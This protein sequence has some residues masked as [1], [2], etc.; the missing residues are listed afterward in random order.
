MIETGRR[1]DGSGFSFKGTAVGIVEETKDRE[2]F[3]KR[4]V[5]I[6]LERARGLP[7]TKSSY[8]IEESR[9]GFK[10]FQGVTLYARKHCIDSG[11]GHPFPAFSFGWGNGIHLRSRQG[12]TGRCPTGRDGQGVG[13]DAA[14]R[15]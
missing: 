2:A 4:S 7:E 10:N 14:R 13:R 5:L 8:P 9:Q 11:D 3:R 6:P 12:F 1:R 15:S